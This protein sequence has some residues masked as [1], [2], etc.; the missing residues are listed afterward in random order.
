MKSQT[1]LFGICLCTLSAA[2]GCGDP[3]VFIPLEN[4]SGPAGVIDGTVTYAG[5]LPCTE[6]GKILGNAVILAFDEKLLPPP[7]G[8]GTTAASLDMVP[9]EVL[10]G[11]VRDKLAFAPD[12]TRVCGDPSGP[13]I[14]VSGT[15]GVGPFPAGTYQIR[16]F[17]DKLG[18]FSPVFSIANLP[19][20]GDVGG[21]AI[22]NA[23]DVLEGAPVKYQSIPLGVPN[24]KGELEIPEDGFHVSGIAVTLGLPLPLE[25]PVFH[26]T[27][28][29]DEFG[30]NED[31]K[32]VVMASD[33]QFEEFSTV[34]P[35]ATEKSF[36]RM[37]FGAGLPNDKVA[38]FN[39]TEPQL[40]AAPP[41]NIPLANP[42]LLYSRQ[43]ANGDGVINGE[44]HVPD[45]DLLP[46]LFPVAVFQ[47]LNDGVRIGGQTSP[48]VVLQGLTIYK[49]LIATA[50]ASAALSE[51]S[52]EVI[53]GIRPAVVCIDSANP[54]KRGVLLTSHKDDKLGNVLIA[55]EE[56]V[57]KSLEALFKRP[58][59]LSYG[60]LPQGEYS[61]NLI[62]GTGQAWTVPNEAG[63]C[64]ANEEAKGTDT[65]GNRAR[66]ASQDVVLTIG[67]PS[68]AAYCK[69][70]PTPQACLPTPSENAE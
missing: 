14:A 4:I 65:C 15:W 50:T 51:A 37:K 34:N 19:T 24:D 54:T 67:A 61:M 11:G 52:N 62:Y 20:K 13:S 36:L 63:V 49:S 5:P 64:A 9:G 25:R 59:D 70:N 21:G 38:A 53:V 31:P 23:A 35:L 46:A 29:I 39:K 16:G 17:Y 43:D 66:L 57:K 28:V 60:C 7:E 48:S 47:K 30:K 6:N 12:G 58:F 55:D 1:K 41:F 45:S 56:A 42:F 32:K 33:Y 3:D 27:E 44:D 40:A 26:A 8:L 2:L 69:A 68:D 22:E 10:F 18:D